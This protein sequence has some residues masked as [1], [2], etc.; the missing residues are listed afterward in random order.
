MY[1]ELLHRPEHIRID[2]AVTRHE[3]RIAG[4][5][6]KRRENGVV[7]G[8]SFPKPTSQR[9]SMVY[10]TALGAWGFLKSRIDGSLPSRSDLHCKLRTVRVSH[11]LH[12][13]EH[14]LLEGQQSLPALQG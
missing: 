12:D 1:Q 4:R 3:V 11:S 2:A 6:K 8:R 13:D 14:E 7:G 10:W 5:L 9:S